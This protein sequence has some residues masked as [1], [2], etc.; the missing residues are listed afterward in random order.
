MQFLHSGQ[1]E[2]F[3]F[4]PECKYLLLANMQNL[5][6]GQDAK[7]AFRDASVQKLHAERVQIL[8]LS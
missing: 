1:D 2:I 4:W 5:H 3:A 6:S 7:I 8:H